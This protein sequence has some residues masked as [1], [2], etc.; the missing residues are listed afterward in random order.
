MV[1]IQKIQIVDQLTLHNN[2]INA[3][4][5]AFTEIGAGDNSRIAHAASYCTAGD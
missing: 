2:S 4:A 5:A 1:N 3:E